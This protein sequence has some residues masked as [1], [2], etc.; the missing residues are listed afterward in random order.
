M[1]SFEREIAHQVESMQ[2][3]IVHLLADLVRIPSVTGQEATVQHHLI[4]LFREFGWE[5]DSW[6]PKK[7][8]V[9]KHPAYSDD[10]LPLGERPVV[11]ARIP[12]SEARS[13]TLILNGH[14]DVVPVGDAQSWRDGP[15]SGA[16]RDGFVWGRGSCDMKAGLAAAIAAVSALQ[17]A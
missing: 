1:Q 8:E 15:W 17:R 13:G 3:E 14:I 4:N 9:Q 12:G 11:V 10:G 2:S 7:E 6:C 16:V 5:V